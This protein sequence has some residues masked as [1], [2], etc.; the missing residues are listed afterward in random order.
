MLPILYFIFEEK[1]KGRRKKALPLA[2]VLALFL[3]PSVKTSAQAPTLTLPESLEL[4]YKNNPLLQANALL[5]FHSS[6]AR[7]K[8]LTQT[9]LDFV[10]EAGAHQ[11]IRQN[12]AIMARSDARL[13]L[14]R[15]TCPTLVVCGD[16]DQLTP[17]ECS[18]EIAGL[19]RGAELHFI[20]QCGHMLTMER[21]E[22]VNALLLEWL[23]RL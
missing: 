1:L 8:A 20:T 5:A 7:D 10:L 9:Y 6:R 15:V 3:C 2:A 19:V 12:R 11:L 23:D 21:P 4:A 17:P 14:P 22:E 18:R 16:S 13:H